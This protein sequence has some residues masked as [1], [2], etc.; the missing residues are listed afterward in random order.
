MTWKLNITEVYLS[1]S[2]RYLAGKYP[3]PGVFKCGNDL[4]V[5]LSTSIGAAVYCVVGG[6]GLL[7]DAGG[8]AV[9]PSTGVAFSEDF[10]LKFAAIAQKPEL[11]TALVS[12]A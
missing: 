1:D 5:V 6:A 11:A 7:A 2:D 10:L 4:A 9:A 3:S 12:K 8:G